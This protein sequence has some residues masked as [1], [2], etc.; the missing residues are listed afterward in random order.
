[1]SSAAKDPRKK[2]IDGLK[3]SFAPVKEQAID[4]YREAVDL[5]HAFAEQVAELL[6]PPGGVAAEV[7]VKLGHQVDQGQEYRVVIRAPEIGLSDYLV[8]A[9]VPF[10]GYPVMLDMFEEADRQCDTAESL[11]AALVELSRRPAMQQRLAA[12]RG[13]L[14]D[15]SLR[16]ERKVVRDLAKPAG[17]APKRQARGG[18]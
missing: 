2:L 15:E 7:K 11:V 17:R 14:A 6:K 16:G 9:F 12:I 8:R 5:L 10:D 18:R 13:A 4:R 3:S 1:M